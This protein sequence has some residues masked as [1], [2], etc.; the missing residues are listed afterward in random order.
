MYRYCYKWSWLTVAERSIVIT[1]CALS[2]I[3]TLRPQVRRSKHTNSSCHL[4]LDLTVWL[5]FH[6]SII[7]VCHPWYM[8]LCSTNNIYNL[9]AHHTMKSVASYGVHHH[10]NSVSSEYL[11][12][13]CNNV[14]D[15]LSELNCA[16]TYVN[17]NNIDVT[18]TLPFCHFSR[19]HLIMLHL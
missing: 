17:N 19:L 7:C 15:W 4:H 8:K 2:Q 16:K 12:F 10:M 3:W 5:I 14:R 11:C 13:S 1:C 9:A 18:S 6:S